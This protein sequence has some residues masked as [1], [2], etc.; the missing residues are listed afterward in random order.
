M[1]SNFVLMY[2]PALANRQAKV[3]L[4]SVDDHAARGW[5]LVSGSTPAPTSTYLTPALGDVRYVKSA[6]VLDSGGKVKDAALPTRLGDT[7]LKAA[8]DAWLAESGGAGG[9]T[10]DTDGMPLLEV[11]VP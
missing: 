10:L 5:L 6:D 2:H 9:L 4:S 1:T 7:A 11:P 3:S 8:Y